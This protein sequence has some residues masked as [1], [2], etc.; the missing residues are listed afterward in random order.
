MHP[1]E[2]LE[3]I[4]KEHDHSAP[5][6][7]ETLVRLD[8]PFETDL[9]SR[10][11]WQYLATRIA[12]ERERLDLPAVHP[13]LHRKLPPLRPD[14]LTPAVMVKLFDLALSYSG[15]EADDAEFA[16]DRALVLAA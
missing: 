12:V 8:T 2:I 11:P 6:A 7:A 15:D 14:W 13:L 9:L 3:S 5:P 4:F 1:P 10:M 16:D